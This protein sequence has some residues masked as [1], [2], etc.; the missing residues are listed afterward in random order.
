MGLYSLPKGAQSPGSSAWQQTLPLWKVRI[1]GLKPQHA[2][3]QAADNL[4][5]S[6]FYIA[7]DDWTR[8]EGK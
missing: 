1:D 2:M 6:A 7:A 4:S 8:R 3:F 5:P